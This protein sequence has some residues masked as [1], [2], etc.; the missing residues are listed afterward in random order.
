MRIE[1]DKTYKK[2]ASIQ[3][4]GAPCATAKSFVTSKHTIELVDKNALQIF[5]SLAVLHFSLRK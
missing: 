2:N 1:N 4:D 3:Y 5:E